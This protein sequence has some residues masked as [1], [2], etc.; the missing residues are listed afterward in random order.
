M[1]L[2]TILE[3]TLLNL[4]LFTIAH[5]IG[6]FVLQS[7]EMGKNKSKYAG[8]LIAHTCILWS[9]TVFIGLLIGYDMTKTEV[10]EFATINSLAHMVIDGIVWN[11]YKANVRNQLKMICPGENAEYIEYRL[12]EWKFWEDHTFFTFIGFDQMSHML[13]IIIVY[14]VVKL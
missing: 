5:F 1:Q 13:T 3:I 11:V 12:E 9:T 7:R 4:G 8:V 6:D 14:G 10:L 2:T